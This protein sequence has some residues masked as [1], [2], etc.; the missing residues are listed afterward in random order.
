MSMQPM[1]QSMIRSE[2]GKIDGSVRM[3][4]E[5][6]V[7]VVGVG[8]EALFDYI[9]LFL[10]DRF[11]ADAG[12]N[13]ENQF[14]GIVF[15]NFVPLVVDIT[16]FSDVSSAF[17][18]FRHVTQEDVVGVGR[19]V[20]EVAQ[21]LRDVL[22]QQVS[23][24]AL[25]LEDDAI[26][27]LCDFE[28]DEFD[29]DFNFLGGDES[30]PA[31]EECIRLEVPNLGSR[32]ARQREEALQVLACLL[33]STVESRTCLAGAFA[34]K[35]APLLSSMIVAI[36]E[37]SS[38]EAFPLAAILQYSTS[39][40]EGA[41]LMAR[42]SDSLA[43]AVNREASTLAEP[44]IA[45]LSHAL[46]NIAAHLVITKKPM[47]TSYRRNQHVFGRTANRSGD[48]IN[49]SAEQR[50][51][52]KTPLPLPLKSHFQSKFASNDSASSGRTTATS[53][54]PSLGSVGFEDEEWLA[55]ISDEEELGQFQLNAPSL[56]ML[57][58]C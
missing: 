36:G 31:W 33:Q 14:Y 53:M 45:K 39:E 10:E 56:G 13:S 27:G 52:S 57:V 23:E 4:G 8:K 54:R 15:D 55:V 48:S 9:R 21:Y 26:V 32:C 20:K 18:V 3:P 49:G 11:C 24:P 42:F 40:A 44:V 43:D 51:F 16:A 38:R 12:G 35:Y 19:L 28:L 50:D 47:I 22:G 58:S 37:M 1:E 46:A 30:E 6:I 25:A 2:V 34:Q 29:D 5:R 7:R 17:V 41:A